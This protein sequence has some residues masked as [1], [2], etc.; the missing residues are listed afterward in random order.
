MA[1]FSPDKS[2]G[3]SQQ[4]GKCVQSKQ[5]CA[6]ARSLVEREEKIILLV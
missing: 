6:E 1:P 4:K 2:G 3:E 5:I